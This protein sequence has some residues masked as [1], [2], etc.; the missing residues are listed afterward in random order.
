MERI[1]KIGGPFNVSFFISEVSSN[2][3]RDLD[4][5]LEFVDISAEIGFD[6][7][8]FQLFK[9]DQLFSIEAIQS[10]PELLD[11]KAWELPRE[12]IPEIKKRCDQKG[13][14]L[15][16]TPFYLDAV[17]YLK[18]YVD[19]FKIASYELLWDDLLV[20]CCNTNKPLIISTGMATMDEIDHAVQ[21]AKQNDCSDLSV[22][23][24]VSSYPVPDH[25][26]NLGAI[27]SMKEYFSLPIGWSDHSNQISVVVAAVLQWNASI[28]EMHLDLDGEGAEF[29]PGHCWLPSDAAMAIDICRKADTYNSLAEKKPADIENEERLW[30]ADPSDGLRPMLIKR[31]EISSK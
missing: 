24:C 21:V 19:F 31:S 2:H 16:C 12:F 17:T 4:R 22:L 9:I 28:V 3:S 23:H 20:K 8:K 30:R 18:Q 15:G 26:I 6:A 29:G 5:C 11:R 13:I 10:K 25:S 1:L 14:Q 27:N 7:V